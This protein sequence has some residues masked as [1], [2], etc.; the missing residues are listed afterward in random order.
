MAV[1]IVKLKDLT[2]DQVPE[3]L[4]AQT[5]FDFD[6]HPFEHKALF[7]QTN[8]V[9]GA[10]LAIDGYATKWIAGKID[11]NRSSV[12]VFK[13]KTPKPAHTIGNFEILLEDDVVFDRR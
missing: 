4:S 12:T 11:Q 13:N 3:D 1:E 6:A 2:R 9:Y 8:S 7:D 5:Y 10:I